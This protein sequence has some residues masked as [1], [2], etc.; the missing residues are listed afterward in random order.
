MYDVLGNAVSGTAF[1]FDTGTDRSSQRGVRPEHAC[2]NPVGDGEG[3]ARVSPACKAFL[4]DQR[5]RNAAGQIFLDQPT[6]RGNPE[7]GYLW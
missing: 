2:L 1:S 6:L 7:L 5:N 4:V 3:R